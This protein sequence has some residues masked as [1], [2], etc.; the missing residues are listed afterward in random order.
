METKKWIKKEKRVAR[1]LISL[2]NVFRKFCL[3]CKF[4][5]DPEADCPECSMY[6]INLIA[7]NRLAALKDLG[8]E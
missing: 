6:K 2:R 8:R 1:K 3:G 4:V 7:V 5:S